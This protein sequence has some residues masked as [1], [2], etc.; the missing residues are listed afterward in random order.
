MGHSLV[1]LSRPRFCDV[2]VWAELLIWTYCHDVRCV[3]NAA[4]LV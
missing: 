1:K 3:G 4:P 2:G